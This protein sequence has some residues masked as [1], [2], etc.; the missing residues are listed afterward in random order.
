MDIFPLLTRTLRFFLTSVLEFDTKRAIQYWMQLLSNM[1]RKTFQTSLIKSMEILELVVKAEE[2]GVS[3]LSKKKG[4]NRSNVHR[5][6]STF[7]FLGYV[8]KN[9]QNR[10]YSPSLRLFELGNLTV[11]RNGLI[12][13]AHPFLKKLGSKFGETNNLAVLDGAKVIYIDKV[14]SSEAL[15]M[16]LAIGRRVPAYC[17]ALGKSL[18]AGLSEK[19]L[20]LYIERTVFKKRTPNTLSKEDLRK[21]LVE[22]RKTGVAIDDEEL[23]LGIRCIAAPVRNH[24][25]E[26]VA[27]I[28]I[29]GPS[30]RM[31]IKELDGMKET[32]RRTASEISRQVGFRAGTEARTL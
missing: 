17:T 18:L 27:S 5:I 21:Q 25:G 6:L 32:I 31:T 24:T 4:L 7:E 15:R 22:I 19:L 29:A 28:S 9:P 13:V 2:I 11:Q 8:V 23:H 16:D 26:I 1:K 10:K 20:N 12:K 30:T 3:A 14:E